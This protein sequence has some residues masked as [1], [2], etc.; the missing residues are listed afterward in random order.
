MALAFESGD[1]SEGV[2]LQMALPNVCRHYAIYGGPEQ[3]KQR[4]E[5]FASLTRNISSSFLG[6]GSMFPPFLRSLTQTELFHWC[7][8]LL[9]LGDFPTFITM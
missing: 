5:E 9:R 1:S 8:W 6:L 3:N 7:S 2:G 4:R